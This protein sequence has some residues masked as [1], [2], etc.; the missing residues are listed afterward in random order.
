MIKKS[1]LATGINGLVGSKFRDLYQEMYSFDTLDI[2]DPNHP[3]DITNLDQV[4]AAFANSDAEAVIHLAAFTDVNAS[5]EQR[6]DKSGIAYKVNVEGTRNIVKAAEET[7]KY[8]I[9][10]S[11]AFVFDGEKSELYTEADSRNPIEWYGQTKA[12]AEEVIENSNTDWIIFRIDFPFRSDRFARPDVVSKIVSAIEE[13]RLPPQFT[14]HTYGPTIIEDFAA[15][16][17]WAI[18][19]RPTGIYHASS[20][21]QWT[22]YNFASLINETLQLGAT[23]EKGDLNEY[24]K[25]LNRPYQKNTAMSTEKLRKEIDVPLQSIKEAIQNLSYAPQV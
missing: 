17:D 8:L 3:V 5:W 4:K 2:S 10:V 20:G 23:I 22:D 15:T 13:H 14:N 6:G 9:H 7:G 25:K 11:T 16:M 21:E 1:I 12:D 19:T 18:R 24:L